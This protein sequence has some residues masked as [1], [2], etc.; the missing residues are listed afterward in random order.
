MTV[1]LNQ[2]HFELFG[3]PARFA[4]D[5]VALEA[6]YRELQRE[7]HPDRF[8]AAPDAERRVSMQLAT[9]VNE[10][11]QTLKSPLKRA[12][13]ILQLRGV[14]P[15]FE[16]NTAMPAGFLME[17]MSWRERIEAGSEKPEALLQL[18]AGLR[19]ESRK[20]YEKLH[21]QLDERRDDE[22]ASQTARMLMFYEKLDDEIDDK[23]A[24][25]ET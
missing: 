11:Y 18:Q 12:V 19:D 8:A 23:L 14:D 1:N 2:N 5:A 22:A 6:R 7:V 9:R 15:K 4:V 16:T 10:A 13:H 25:L 3:L 24:E 21:G 20:I 17:Q